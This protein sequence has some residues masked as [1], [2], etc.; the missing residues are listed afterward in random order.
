MN[1][2]I[3]KIKLNSYLQYTLVS[4]STDNKTAVVSIQTTISKL[5]LQLIGGAGLLLIIVG[6]VLP[7]TFINTGNK[8]SNTTRKLF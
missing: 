2:Q 7:L 8:I 5:Q 1:N 6:I 3:C 4:Y